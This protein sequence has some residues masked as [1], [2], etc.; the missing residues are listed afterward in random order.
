MTRMA[1]ASSWPGSV[2]M[3]SFRFMVGMASGQSCQAFG[4]EGVETVRIGAAKI[5][6]IP[7]TVRDPPPVGDRQPHGQLAMRL[8]RDVDLAALEEFG[9]EQPG[10]DA[11]VMQRR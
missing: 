4:E 1:T 6:N 3:M 5:E 2:R 9:L 11:G 7:R 10:D 8:D